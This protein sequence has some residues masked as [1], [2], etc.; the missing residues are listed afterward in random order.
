VEEAKALGTPLLLS[1]LDV[2]RE[3]AGDR[4][5]FFD[6]RSPRELADA[7]LAAQ[8]AP[9]ADGETRRRDAAT[10]SLEAQNTYARKLRETLTAA[11]SER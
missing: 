4:A 7:L 3:Q 8:A 6:P 9:C 1:S 5:T 2:H 11:L 10:W